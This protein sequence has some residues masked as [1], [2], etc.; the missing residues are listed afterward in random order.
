M[1]E[2]VKRIVDALNARP[3]LRDAVLKA[4]ATPAVPK[5]ESLGPWEQ[6]KGDT[7][8]RRDAQGNARAWVSKVSQHAIWPDHWGRWCV[9]FER[10]DDE[11]VDGPRGIGD[12]TFAMG[13]ADVGLQAAG[14]VLSDPTAPSPLGKVAGPWFRGDS[15]CMVRL[16]PGT[17]HG[18]GEWS[19]GGVASVD[20]N[21]EDDQG[22]SRYM[23]SAVAAYG[24]DAVLSYDVDGRGACPEERAMERAD[25]WLLAQGWTL[26]E[27]G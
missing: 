7:H 14:W 25:R 12:A 20:F 8:V 17:P 1:D 26:D 18:P 9:D 23:W 19:L 16:R 6:G 24:E 5:P 27:S 11:F 10:P 4:L 3:E 13:L 2:D 22:R 21:G 15:S